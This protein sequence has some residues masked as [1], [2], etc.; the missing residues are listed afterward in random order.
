MTKNGS[1]HELTTLQCLSNL[2]FIHSMKIFLIT[3]NNE[4]RAS[5]VL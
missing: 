2:S 3:D 1:I 4:L 5:P